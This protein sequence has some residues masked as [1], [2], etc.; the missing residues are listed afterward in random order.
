MSKKI[1]IQ[2]KKKWLDMYEQGKTEVQVAREMRRDPRTIVKGIEEASKD[3]RLASAEAEMLRNALFKHQD[4]LTGILKNIATMLVMPPDNLEMR[5]EREGFLAPISLSGAL[6]KHPSEEQMTLEVHIEDKLEWELLKEHLRQD[7]LWEYIKQWRKAMID[8]ALARW[9]FKQAVKLEL[10]RDTDLKFLN[11]KD[12]KQSDN[13]LRELVDLLYDV[14]THR[15]LGI[16]NATDVGDVIDTKLASYDNTAESRQKIVSVFN[17]LPG[18]IQAYKVKSTHE[19]LARV[20]R[21]AKRQVDEIML[22]GMI[23]GK[24]RV[25]RRLSR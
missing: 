5:E 2:E 24:C 13:L 22:L 10:V 12:S 20:T 14:T 18:T 11:Y 25:C 23:T 4:Q 6:L 21:L 16:Q 17:S 8:H 1:S 15:F 9:Q 7:K 3:R 19:E